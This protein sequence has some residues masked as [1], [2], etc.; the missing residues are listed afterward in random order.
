MYASRYNIVMILGSVRNGRMADRVS[1]CVKKAVDKNCNVT[2][3]TLDP[4]TVAP[5][6]MLS[7]Q[8]MHFQ[9]DPKSESPE[10]MHRT[11]EVIEQA[12]GFVMVSPEYNGMMPAALLN[13]LNCFPPTSFRHRPVGIVTYTMGNTGA[14]RALN[15]LRPYASELGMVVVPGYVPIPVVQDTIDENG[16][17]ENQLV[18]E[19][20]TKLVRN[21]EWYA[22]AIRSYKNT[23]KCAD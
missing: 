14:M 15:V 21:V 13:L 4:A 6:L 20:M 12:D 2:L 9:L 10:W 3:K 18:I 19:N 5:K 22:T 7:Q 17:T 16:N 11:K 23:T 1:K 8:P